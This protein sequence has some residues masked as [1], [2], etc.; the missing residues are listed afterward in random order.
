MVDIDYYI[1]FR[2][3]GIKDEAV[4]FLII[5]DDEIERINRTD[6]PNDYVATRPRITRCPKESNSSMSGLSLF[7]NNIINFK[8][9]DHE[10]L[11]S[12]N[13]GYRPGHDR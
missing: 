7:T 9:N 3:S 12:Y 2:S 6:E 4:R 10:I 13:S 5:E 1:R 8:L 11:S